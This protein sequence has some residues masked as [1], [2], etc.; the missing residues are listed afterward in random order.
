LSSHY[1]SQ[2]N[3]TFQ[4]LEDA[5]RT[6][7]TF[8]DFIFRIKEEIK[9]PK[10]KK[11]N[12][13]ISQTVKLAKDK[14]EKHMDDNLN[15]PHALAAIFNMINIVNKEID[16]GDADKKSLKEVYEFLM[17]ANEI[18]D[19][20]ELKEEKLSEEEKKLIELR[21]KYRKEK[22][23]KRADEIRAQLKEK[24]IVLEDTPE[25]VRWKKVR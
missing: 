12:K 11:Q 6:V 2:L 7:D 4:S 9:S 25:G 21:E 14:F 15:T 24:G 17:K 18:L 13:K 20:I 10:T 5:K 23:Y 3:F 8:N 19:I 1:R 16:V 22:N